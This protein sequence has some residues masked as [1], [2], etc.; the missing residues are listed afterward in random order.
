MSRHDAA[1][2]PETVSPSATEQCYACLKEKDLDDTMELLP[3]TVR[4]VQC[5]VCFCPDHIEAHLRS[6]VKRNKPPHET[7][8]LALP[9][10]NRAR[11]EVIACTC[12]R[13]LDL[14]KDVSN[15]AFSDLRKEE[16]TAT[17]KARST[18]KTSGL[19]KGQLSQE[20]EEILKEIKDRINQKWA[21]SFSAVLISEFGSIPATTWPNTGNFVHALRDSDE[22]Q[23][24]VRLL[25]SEAIHAAAMIANGS[26]FRSYLAVRFAPGQ[27]IKEPFPW[28]CTC[29]PQPGPGRLSS[30]IL[31]DQKSETWLQLSVSF[32]KLFVGMKLFMD[33]DVSG[34]SCGTILKAVESSTSGPGNSKF[35]GQI[36]S[37]LGNPD[38]EAALTEIAVSLSLFNPPVFNADVTDPDIY[39]NTCSAKKLCK[40]DAEFVPLFPKIRY[41]FCH[42]GHATH[43]NLTQTSGDELNH[44]L[45]ATFLRMNLNA[46]QKFRKTFV[47]NCEFSCEQYVWD[48]SVFNNRVLHNGQTLFISS[49]VRDAVRSSWTQFIQL[50]P[51][52]EICRLCMLRC[53]S[54]DLE[55]RSK[56]YMANEILSLFRFMNPLPPED[57]IGA[58]PELSSSLEMWISDLRSWCL[59]G[60][61][62]WPPEIFDIFLVSLRAKEVDLSS[63]TKIAFFYMLLLQ[64]SAKSTAFLETS[65]MSKI[66]HKLPMLLGCDDSFLP[67]FSN[68]L[69]VLHRQ[70]IYE[71]LNSL[72]PQKAFEILN[73]IDQTDQTSSS[74]EAGRAVPP[75]KAA[76][77]TKQIL[78]RERLA[79]VSKFVSD[80]APWTSWLELHHEKEMES[81][82]ESFGEHHF[83]PSHSESSNSTPTSPSVDG[84]TE[85]GTNSSFLCLFFSAYQILRLRAH[86]TASFAKKFSKLHP[87][88]RIVQAHPMLVPGASVLVSFNSLSG[89]IGFSWDQKRN[90]F[91]NVCE[92]TLTDNTRIQFDASVAY[93]ETPRM[94]LF[95]D[96]ETSS[97]DQISVHASPFDD[98]QLVAT[99]LHVHVSPGM[100]EN[101]VFVLMWFYDSLF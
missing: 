1:A 92:I 87:F 13:P 95:G 5:K 45:I 47:E 77:R 70:L 79:D 63:N 43:A 81:F 11:I 98:I 36:T 101:F 54:N 22:K 84:S 90:I 23:P 19:K 18:A 50:M 29:G 48:A 42:D 31:F 57:I 20:D 71:W 21:E 93:E 8:E 6:L 10:E 39:R 55:T 61:T 67:T 37:I 56:K 60:A 91:V 14:L 80:E 97:I 27:H 9:V 17:A 15:E 4:C 66:L 96:D 86:L 69:R 78:S 85:H 40:R 25:F 58:K 34:L 82:L 46:M 12:N 88:V 2:V 28:K 7:I 99:V 53:S 3:A 62:S 26:P 64:S 30:E 75:P 65:S 49:T 52:E 59:A 74:L 16:E 41:T 94:F 38:G 89:P 35:L 68:H 73:L 100:F 44:A 51:F 72:E 33:S 24:Q 76:A 83:N 32:C